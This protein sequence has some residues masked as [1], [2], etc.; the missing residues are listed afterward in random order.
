MNFARVYF[1]PGNSS[2]ICASSRKKIQHPARVREILRQRR[3]VQDLI[4]PRILGKITPA[5]RQIPRLQIPQRARNLRPWL[6]KVTRA[7]QSVM[8]RSTG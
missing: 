8:L 6:V 3:H 1:F 2:P 4:E 5:D 7:F